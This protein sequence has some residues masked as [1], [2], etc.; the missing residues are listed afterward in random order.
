MARYLARACPHCNGYV[1]ITIVSRRASAAPSRERSL[2]AVRL[3][4]GVDCDPG[5]ACRAAFLPI[6]NRNT[7]ES[8]AYMMLISMVVE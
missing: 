6:Q 8:S 3:S 4:H 7:T 5:Q 1:G 2:H